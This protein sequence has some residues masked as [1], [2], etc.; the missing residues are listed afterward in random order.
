MDP[1]AAGPSR[2]FFAKKRAR[3]FTKTCPV[4]KKKSERKTILQVNG[5]QII[6]DCTIISMRQG[7]NLAGELESGGKRRFSA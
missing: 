2:P 7:E 6:A 5:I 4:R 1:A 3:W